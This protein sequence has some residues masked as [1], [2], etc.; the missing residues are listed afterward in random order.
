MVSNFKPHFISVIN[1]KKFNNSKHSKS[2]IIWNLIIQHSWYPG[3][4]N[5]EVLVGEL[6]GETGDTAGSAELNNA[7]QNTVSS[8]PSHAISIFCWFLNKNL[9]CVPFISGKNYITDALWR[10]DTYQSG[11]KIL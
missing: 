1:Y 10:P 3:N 8:S 2:P 9:V 7:K 5:L 11:F 4:K 6:W